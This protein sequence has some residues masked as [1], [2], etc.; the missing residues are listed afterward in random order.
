MKT[1]IKQAI[2]E[3]AKT[4]NPE[5]FA[6]MNETAYLI[7]EKATS[8]LIKKACDWIERNGAYYIGFEQGQPC[9][10]KEFIES[11]NEYMQA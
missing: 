5:E 3:I 1:Y 4:E 8:L 10:C 11:F 7:A 9:I 2:K 6:K